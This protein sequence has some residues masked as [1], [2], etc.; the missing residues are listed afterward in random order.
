MP[1]CFWWSDAHSSDA[2]VTVRVRHM[3]AM[4]HWKWVKV[5]PGTS[6]PSFSAAAV[7]AAVLARPG[8]GLGWLA[9]VWVCC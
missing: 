9:P 7:A 2:W 3:S 1:G 6:N 4:M 8:A 5:M